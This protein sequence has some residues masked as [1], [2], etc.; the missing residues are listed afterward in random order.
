MKFIL[1]LVLIFLMPT[2]NATCV[3]L[4]HG[5]ARSEG[6]MKKLGY[7]L[8]VAGYKVINLSLIHI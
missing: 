3:I 7:A 4:L 1:P 2:V 8:T 6:S 5:L